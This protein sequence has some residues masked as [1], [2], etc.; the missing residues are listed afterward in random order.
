MAVNLSAQEAEL[1]TEDS[2]MSAWG[3]FGL[4]LAE[5]AVSNSTLWAFNRYI[6]QSDYGMISLDSM[7]TNL[8]GSWVWDQDEFSVNHLGHPYQGAIYYSAARS[9]GSEPWASLLAT[10]FGSLTWELFMETE[11]PSK[12]DLIV[13]T[14]GGAS[15]GEMMYRLS[16]N[17]LYDSHGKIEKP[18]FIRIAGATILSPTTSL[19]NS[20]L[21]SSFHEEVAPV[22]GW[23]S[24][25]LGYSK[26]DIGVDGYGTYS[27]Y[28]GYSSS[29]SHHLNYGTPFTKKNSKPYDHF[30]LQA[31]VGLYLEQY[32][33]TF[34][35]EGLLKGQ[36]LYSRWN[37]DAQN[38]LGV[39][40]HYDF[41][42]NEL[43]NLGANSVGFG[44]QHSQPLGNSWEIDWALH[45]GMVYMG[46]SDILFL[47]FNDIYSEAPDYE[48]RTYNLSMGNLLKVS[49][50][51]DYKEK[52]FFDWQYKFYNLIIIEEAV[53][54]GGTTGS[55]FVGDGLFS[56]RYVIK[57]PWFVG[58]NVRFYHKQSLYTNDYPDLTEWLWSY[59]LQ[60][61]YT[62]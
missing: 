48:R 13:T 2:D 5:V 27:L 1:S 31:G 46:A 53:P 45:L 6:N 37:E 57:D 30:S 41:I 22:S 42:Y 61:G 43:I 19:N 50:A 8:F 47:K 18:G 28:Q 4:G 60:A 34:Y 54:E 9:A 40:M 32:F 17:L 38:S 20:L 11:T 16:C 10:S 59:S 14:L 39:Y 7:E 29:F 15:L 3:S 26:G 25:G 44:W 21:G 52:L 62:F 51:L 58:A 33:L 49:C 12:N 56:V 24:I 23:T 35:S 36:P 55:E